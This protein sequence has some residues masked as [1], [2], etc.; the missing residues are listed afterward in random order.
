M[1][2]FE[3][4]ADFFGVLLGLVIAQVASRLAEA[5]D[6]HRERPLG[7]LTPLLAAFV[8]CDV[9]G[10]WLWIWSARD[11]ITVS[12]TSVFLS[13]LLAIAYFL[14]AGVMFPRAPGRWASYDEHYWA[15][16]R[17]VLGG[18]FAV[19][20]ATV[21]ANSHAS[22]Q[23]LT[24]SGSIL[25]R[26][27]TSFRSWLCNSHVG[28]GRTLRCSSGFSFTSSRWVSTFCRPPNGVTR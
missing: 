21:I 14:A 3:F 18:I 12:W 13:T 7:L 5:I 4:L 28:V 26:S 11:V 6:E 8:L 22:Y 19:N 27:A 20:V 1:N 9:T 16:K 10:F 24:T 2:D 23:R 17:L 15:R 25:T